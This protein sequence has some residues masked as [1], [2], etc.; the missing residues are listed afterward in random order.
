MGTEIRHNTRDKRDG[1]RGDTA[2]SSNS[3]QSE[4]YRNTEANPKGQQEEI[5]SQKIDLIIESHGNNIDGNKMNRYHKVSINILG[6]GKQTIKG[7]REFI[8]SRTQADHII[9]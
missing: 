8:R 1:C 2:T 7:A 9:F 5:T 4:S 3:V 6:E